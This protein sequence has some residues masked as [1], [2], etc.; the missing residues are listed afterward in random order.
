MKLSFS[1]LFRVKAKSFPAIKSPS[2][3]AS[4]FIATILISF[5][6]WKILSESLLRTI[7]ELI[8]RSFKAIIES[9]LFRVELAPE[10]VISAS[11]FDCISALLTKLPLIVAEKSPSTKPEMKLEL[12]V[13]LFA[14]ILVDPSTSNAP[15]K[16]TSLVAS[17]V[18]FW[19]IRFS[20]AIFWSLLETKRKLPSDSKFPVAILFIFCASIKEVLPETVEKIISPELSKLVVLISVLSL[21]LIVPKLS[22]LVVVAFSVVFEAIKPAARLSKSLTLYVELSW[23]ITLPELLNSSEV[24]LKSASV[25]ISPELVIS[26][27]EF[28]KLKSFLEKIVPLLASDV[29]ICKSTI[30]LSEFSLEALSNMLDIIFKSPVSVWTAW[31]V[32]SVLIWFTA[33]RSISFSERIIPS[34]KYISFWAIKLKLSSVLMNASVPFK[35]KFLPPPLNI[36]DLY[37]TLS[38]A[39]SPVALISISLIA[40]LWLSSDSEEDIKLSV[41]FLVDI[42]KSLFASITPPSN[43]VFALVAVKLTSFCASILARLVSIALSEACVEEIFISLADLIALPVSSIFPDEEISKSP[44]PV[45]TLFFILTPTPSSVAIK[46][47]LLAYIPPS[48]LASIA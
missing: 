46:R 1:R 14:V 17:I 12:L 41:K 44:I 24:I 39:T 10:R 36:L 4:A 23:D 7:P 42:N 38:K 30:S 34:F 47:T 32:E 37:P 40:C 5:S 2:K 18:K 15:A 16:V 19:P 22:K 21:T 43:N 28:P 45:A 25:K 31:K 20:P 48:S 13:K 29:E 6:A 8:V 3:S 27:I 26:K 35:T 9:L 11:L 33:S